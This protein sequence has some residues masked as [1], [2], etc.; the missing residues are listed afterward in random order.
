M[1]MDFVGYLYLRIYVPKNIL[2][3]DELTC[4]V[5]QQTS[6][7]EITCATNQQNFDNQQTQQANEFANVFVSL[8]PESYSV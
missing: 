5:M 8:L 3:I 6:T 4:I 1:F 7:D 2:Q